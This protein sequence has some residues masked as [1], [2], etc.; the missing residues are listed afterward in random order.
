MDNQSQPGKTKRGRKYWKEQV[1]K[2]GKS[3]LTVAAYSRRTSVSAERLYKWRRR[4]RKEGRKEARNFIELSR[5]IHTPHISESYEIHL[6]P[7]PHIRIGAC[8]NPETLKQL[9]E[10]I[11]GL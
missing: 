1:R 2:L 5:S 4:F 8:F 9:I 11:R 7:A 10:V 3:G 6:L